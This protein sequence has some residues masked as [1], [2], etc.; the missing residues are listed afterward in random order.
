MMMMAA[1]GGEREM[2]MEAARVFE[3][4]GGSRLWMAEEDD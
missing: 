2:K 3:V 1:D 4:E